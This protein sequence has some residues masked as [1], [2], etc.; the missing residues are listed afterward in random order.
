[1]G[2]KGTEMLYILKS[3]IPCKTDTSQLVL[4]SC[5]WITQLQLFHNDQL[6]IRKSPYSKS[7]ETFR[8]KDKNDYGYEI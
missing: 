2:K 7:L 4:Q 3:N 5:V 6:S 1:M 8:F